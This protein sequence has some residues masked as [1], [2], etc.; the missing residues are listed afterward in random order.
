MK[1]CPKNMIINPVTGRCVKKT[2]TIGKR[3]VLN[4]EV[5][6][7]LKR[8]RNVRDLWNWWSVNGD[9]DVRQQMV[10]LGFWDPRLNDPEKGNY[11]FYIMSYEKILKKTYKI[12]K[13]I[14]NKKTKI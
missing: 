4:G 12:Y 11:P 14:K 3:L 10:K 7:D 8:Y 5:H 9:D 13:K 1:K 6:T 2:G